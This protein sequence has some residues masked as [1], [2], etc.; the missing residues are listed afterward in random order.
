MK[1]W[2]FIGFLWAQNLLF[3]QN[4]ELGILFGASVYTGDIE[5]TPQNFLPVTH[6]AVGVF[7]RQHLGEHFAIRALIAIGGLSADEK[8]Y[9]TNAAREKRSFNFKGTVAELGLIPEWR[10]FN[11]GNIHFGFFAGVSAIYVNP[12]SYFNDKGS[13]TNAQLLED[14]N[15]KY[16][17]IAVAI[18][19]G[20]SVNWNVNETTALGLELGLRKTFT[21]YLDGFSATA[22]PNSKDYYAIAAVSFSKFFSMGNGGPRTQHTRYRRRGVNCPSFN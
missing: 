12:K 19:M 14:Q 16:P 13:S 18:P 22:N 17:K 15:Q 21:D 2:L 11:V 4:T 8:K 3:S 20:G 1:H 7:G 6:P 5:V 10:P 9:P